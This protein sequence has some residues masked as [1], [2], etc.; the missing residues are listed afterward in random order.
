MTPREDIQR[1]L[2]LG[3]FFVEYQPIVSLSSGEICGIESLLRWQ[4]TER[5]RLEPADFIDH[6]EQT[7]L[8]NPLTTFVLERAV[9][10]WC[11]DTS[12]V[13]FKIAI[14]ISPR[15]LDDPDLSE[16]IRGILDAWHMP[17]SR[18]SIE[19]TETKI[20]VD[21]DTAAASL[22]RL[23]DMGVRVVVDD[24]GRGFSS[25]SHLRQLPVDELKIDKTFIGA[26]PVREDRVIV[27]ST[28]AL[29]HNL[30]L[31]VVAEGVETEESRDWLL[32]LG[33][34]AAQGF[35]FSPA[36]SP[37]DLQVWMRQRVAYPA[38]EGLPS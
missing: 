14:N 7:G 30:G 6:A 31:T 33:C 24:F 3:H 32:D 17:P 13:P 2:D 15:T 36:I 23:R 21:I 34:D 16:H 25:L 4:H 11:G 20:F 22:C 27:E 5:G 12:G 10:E 37:V 26:L 29:A 1:G 19:I 38:G 18:V 28:I 35:F 8:I 9:E